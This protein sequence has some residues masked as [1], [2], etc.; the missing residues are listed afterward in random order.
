MTFQLVSTDE[1]KFLTSA[2]DRPN[3]ATLY[4]ASALNKNGIVNN[5]WDLN[6]DNVTDLL[7]NIGKKD[8]VGLT[9]LSPTAR[10][11]RTLIKEIQKFTDGQVYVGG[12]HVTGLPGDFEPAQEIY[13]YGESELVSKL[14]GRN[15]QFD[16]NRYPVPSRESVDLRRYDM[17]I[18]GLK[19]TTMISSRGCP[20]NCSFCGNFDKIQKV[21]SLDNIEQEIELL[22]AYGYQAVYLLDD[23]FTLNREHAK[24]VASILK[25]N[26]MKYRIE[27][28]ANLI[29][30]EMARTLGET[31]CLVAGMGIESG[32]DRVLEKCTK[33]V[34][35]GRVRQSVRLLGQ[36]GVNTKGF[37]I[38]GLP[39]ESYVDAKQT[40]DFAVEMKGLGMKQADF[41]ILQPFPGT[42]IYKDPDKFGIRIL[43]RDYNKYMVASNQETRCY[44]DNGSMSP[45]GVEAMCKLARE[46]FNE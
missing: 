34:T 13:G 28:R 11:A 26:G 1:R 17:R 27:T 2:G 8:Q 16:I 29:D 14:T 18:N 31:G 19:A 44:V 20:F 24:S 6:H 30:E 41:Y 22:K 5:V 42:P 10:Q 46:T 9:F 39:G 4:L 37:F 36:N 7:R 43:D 40:I 45:K 38:F 21:R 12:F 33:G 32:S 35:T 23:S 25:L 15:E 3:L